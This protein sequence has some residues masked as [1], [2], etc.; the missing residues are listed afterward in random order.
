[1]I[2]FL[3]FSQ[4]SALSKADEKFNNFE[5]IKA[6]EI[7]ENLVKNGQGTP[8]IFEKIANAYYDN[9]SYIQANKWFEK[10]YVINPNMKSENHFRYSNT[11]KAT[12]NFVESE[13]Q[14][15]IFELACPNQIRT[16]LLKSKNEF[17]PNFVFSNLKTLPI[18]SE[19]SD[20]GTVVKG[21]TLL[22]SSSRGQV[23]SDK[24]SL[25]TGKYYTNFYKTIRGKNGEYSTPKLFSLA[26]YSIFNDATPAFSS[27]GKIMYYTQ[28]YLVKDSKEKLVNNGFKLYKS[29]LKKGIWENKECITFSQK[30]SVKIAHPSISPDG[31]FLYFASDMPGTIGDS[32]LFRIAINSEGS[33]GNIEH[34]SDKINTEGRESFPFIT[35]NNILIFAS[36][37]HPGM[38]GL[39]LYSIDLSFP[40]AKVTS[41]GPDVNSAFDDFAM[42]LNKD[43]SKGYFTS[44]RPGGMGD[45]DIYSFDVKEIQNT[46]LILTS[47]TEIEISGEIKDEISNES[48]SNVS[49][50]LI[51]NEKQEIA[52]TK[53]D[54]KGNFSFIGVQSN[55]DYILKLTKFDKIVRLIP[56]SVIDKD[57]YTVIIISKNQVLPLVDITKIST[58]LGDDVSKDLNIDKIYFDFDKSDI[59]PDAQIDLDNLV[60]YMNLNTSIKIEIG[61]HTDS[62]GSFASNLKLSQKR[63][64]STLK[65]IVDQGIAPSR[66]SAVGYGESK[67]VN[68]CSDGVPCNKEQNQ[69]NRRSTFV[70]KF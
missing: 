40:D 11:L 22:F 31:K 43:Y 39:D 49:I 38:G 34:L 59:R 26:S 60:A 2:P 68:N 53:T 64:N 27:D 18:N 4:K 14:L 48:L 55:S 65:Y 35:E 70:I 20:Y 50:A 36:N 62:M 13:Q 37:G 30:D 16:K 10:L 58:K 45:D 5:Y 42:V 63:A 1:M 6:I 24:I 46:K 47:V 54:V 3:I 67:L 15:K 33:F 8:E 66:L 52:K 28:N 12:S 57:L 29:I 9:A 19:S 69:L 56:V 32:D 44:N 41:L 25:R 61:S 23:L 17:K 7:Y 51:D 21:D